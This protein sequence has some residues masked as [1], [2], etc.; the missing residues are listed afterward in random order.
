MSVYMYVR[1]LSHETPCPVV[2]LIPI[3]RASRMKDLWWVETLRSKYDLDITLSNAN[4]QIEMVPDQHGKLDKVIDDYNYVSPHHRRST[5]A[6][7]QH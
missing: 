7:P 4:I 5:K 6:P 2:L 1:L 3:E